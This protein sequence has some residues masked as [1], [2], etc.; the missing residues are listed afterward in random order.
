MVQIVFEACP[1]EFIYWLF[2]G[3]CVICFKQGAEINEIEPRS[4]GK[5]SMRWRNRV[6]M[7]SEHHREYHHNGVSKE[8][9]NALKEQRIEFLETIGRS[10]YE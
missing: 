1:N 3:R 6:L 9:I 10:E 8:A 2:K 5:E 7:C 4:S